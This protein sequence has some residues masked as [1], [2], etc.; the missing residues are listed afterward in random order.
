MSQT[1]LSLSLNGQGHHP[2]A[3]R[4]PGASS[5]RATDPG[6]LRDL[7]RQADAAGIDVLLT[8]YP[9]R[10][11]GLPGPERQEAV[12]FDALSVAAALTGLTRRI[13][14]CG[15]V[16]A[17]YTEPFNLARQMTAF[18][19]VSRGRAAVLL[20]PGLDPADRPNFVRL[21]DT[22][23]AH[24]DG[25]SAEFVTV[26]KGLFDT[27]EDGALVLDK[28][29]SIFAHPGKIAPIDHDGP[30]FTIRTTLNA[31][32][33]PQ[34]HPVL[35]M[36]PI[37]EAEI[38]LAKAQADVALVAG[39]LATMMAAASA[40]GAPKTFGALYVTLAETEAD[41]KARVAA[42]DALGA[43]LVGAEHFVGTPAGLA[44]RLSNWPLDGVTLMP[45]VLPEGLERIAEAVAL[46]RPDGPGQVATL[47]ETLG[48]ARPAGRRT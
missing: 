6:F 21:R 26:M 23:A 13:G 37:T 1:L 42:L 47:R 29:E 32:R 11:T 9:A 30:Y 22:D 33:P 43:P 15:T 17:T 19:H 44:E 18:D 10:G 25:R 36:A 20:L 7:A 40:I 34:G 24:H 28:P 41:A 45:T 4:L 5:A 27:W 31:P 2:G 3:W 46:L 16:S 14:L 38:A 48:L 35:V 12:H 39:P 8:E